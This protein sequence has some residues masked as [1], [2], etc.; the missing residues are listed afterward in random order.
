MIMKTKVKILPQVNPIA[1]TRSR[2][3]SK[4]LIY[5]TSPPYLLLL[6]KRLASSLHTIHRPLAR[7]QRVPIPN[8]FKHNARPSKKRPVD[9]GDTSEE[10]DIQNDFEVTP[11]ITDASPSQFINDSITAEE[12][13]AQEHGTSLATIRI[14]RRIHL[15]E[16]LKQV[17]E[18]DDIHEVLSGM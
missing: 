18:L 7:S 10:E 3:V 9:L 16:K 5:E 12:G 14:H 8:A 2:D 4:L 13:P 1:K 11:R 17:F 6:V 15:A